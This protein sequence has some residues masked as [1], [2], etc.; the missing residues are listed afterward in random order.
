MTHARASAKTMTV[1]IERI[2]SPVL[3]LCTSSTCLAPAVHRGAT[4][5]DDMEGMGLEMVTD[6]M[7]KFKTKAN[8]ES[9]RL[10]KFCT[11]GSLPASP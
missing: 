3:I 6:Y 1:T 11:L 10:L 7:W 4:Q 8:P 5:R 2:Y 9:K